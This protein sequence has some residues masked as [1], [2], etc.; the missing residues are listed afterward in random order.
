MEARRCMG[1]Q[2]IE[3]KWLAVIMMT[4]DHAAM[5]FLPYDSWLYMLARNLGRIAAPLFAYLLVAGFLVSRDQKS[6]RQR[7]LMY[8]LLS[9]FPF[10]SLTVAVLPE[11]A[12]NFMSAMLL[13]WNVMAT[14]WASAL[15]LQIWGSVKNRSN[16]AKIAYWFGCCFGWLMLSIFSDNGGYIPVWVLI[17]FALRNRRLIVLFG[18]VASIAVFLAYGFLVDDLIF[19]PSIKIWMLPGYL[20]VPVILYRFPPPSTFYRHSIPPPG[21]QRNLFYLWYPLHMQLFAALASRVYFTN[22]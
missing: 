8:A 1:R 4:A 15:A 6:Y 3:L 18:Y 13:S 12:D 5:V 17:F 20:M 11:T 2:E 16:I 9:Q 10:V 14:L 19:P 21:W 7:L 22:L